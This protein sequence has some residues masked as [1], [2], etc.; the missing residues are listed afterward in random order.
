[1][2]AHALLLQASLTQDVAEKRDDLQ[3]ALAIYKALKDLQ[4]QSDTLHQLMHLAEQR[5]DAV[6]LERLQGELDRV[7]EAMMHAQGLDKRD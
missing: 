4:G 7:G 1:V 3:D 2:A 6:E 5:G